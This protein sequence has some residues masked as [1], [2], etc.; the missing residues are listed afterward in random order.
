MRVIGTLLVL[1]G[2]L[3]ANAAAA[4]IER[5]GAHRS[6]SAE[7][8]PHL[9]LQWADEPAW[10]D[11]GIGVGLRASIPLID[12]GPIKTINNNMGIGFGLDW[13]HFDDCWWYGPNRIR[14]NNACDA[15]D[16]WLPIV[17]Q[18]N[19][20]F[21]ELI[22]AYFE[23]GLGI[24]HSVWDQLCNNNTLQCDGSDTDLEL[25]AALGIRFHV[26][27]PLALTL[28]LG[29]PSVNFGVSFWL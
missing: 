5:P 24:Q 1:A 21:S 27:D 11:D 19:F 7:I 20:F 10:G 4:Q 3:A 8:E 22:S 12:N 17:M 2:T 29:R 18:W 25:V 13:A 26:A 16:F 28:R 6:Y 14:V 23:I 9:V 15:D